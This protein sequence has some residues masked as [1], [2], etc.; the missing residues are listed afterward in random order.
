MKAALVYQQKNPSVP[1]PNAATPQQ[2][3]HRM[4]DMLLMAALS[5]LLYPLMKTGMKISRKEG[6]L[7]L[8]IYIAY[9]AYLIVR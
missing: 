5:I 3:I 2:V 1:L 6:A 9:T 4:V 7:L 8:A